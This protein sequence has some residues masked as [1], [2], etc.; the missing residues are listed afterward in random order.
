MPTETQ[1][2]NLFKYDPVQ[3]A[4][5]T[6]N[7]QQSLNDNWDKI[8][9]YSLSMYNVLN[10]KATTSLDNLTDEGRGKFDGQWIDIGHITVFSRTLST[11]LNP[12]EFTLD[13]LPDNDI[14]EVLFQAGIFLVV[15]N[16]YNYGSIAI[17]TDIVTSAFVLERISAYGNINTYSKSCT[18][19]PIKNKKIY[20]SGDP[21]NKN[22]RGDF[23]AIAYRKIGTGFTTTQSEA[24]QDE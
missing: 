8:D 22:S 9:N 23:V 17:A 4:K 2:L 24:T 10:T 16:A 7:L 13:F 5:S 14:Y 18:M 1:N 6:F 19:L 21:E 3:D 11:S 15:S 20:L 12:V